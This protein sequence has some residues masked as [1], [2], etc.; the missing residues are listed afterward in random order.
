M[1]ILKQGQSQCSTY[2]S[3]RSISHGDVVRFVNCKKKKL[4]MKVHS[5]GHNLQIIKG[6]NPVC[7]GQKAYFVDLEEGR[8][9]M[10]NYDAP[11][12]PVNAVVYLQEEL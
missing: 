9:T 6:N 12:I 10:M 4:Y 7:Q 2:P 11:V 8:I 1:K 5:S 3:A